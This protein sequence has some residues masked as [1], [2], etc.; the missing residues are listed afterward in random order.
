MNHVQ[1]V[2]QLVSGDGDGILPS[3]S[4]SATTKGRH[5]VKIAWELPKQPDPQYKQLL[6]VVNVVGTRFSSEINS[7]IR[8]ESLSV[9]SA[10]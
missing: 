5:A 10:N 8:L 2:L 1:Y 4:I 7:D 3:P 6:Y 9:A